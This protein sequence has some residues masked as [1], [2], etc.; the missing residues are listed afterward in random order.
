MSLITRAR[1]RAR[2]IQTKAIDRL[3]SSV[4]RRDEVPNVRLAESIVKKDDEE[5]ILDLIR[6][7]AN[8]D[9]EIQSDCIKVL[10]EVGERKPAMIARFAEEFGALL[11]SKN[12]RVA[13]G[14]MTAL[15]SIA[16][17]RP[18]TL[19]RMMPKIIASANK[20]SVISRDHAVSILTKLASRKEYSDDAVPKLLEQLRRSPNNQLPAYAEKAI[21]IVDDKNRDRFLKVLRSRLSGIQ[22]ESK[23]RRLEKVIARLIRGSP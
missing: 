16:M 1:E 3:A 13:W 11:E 5:A 2:E 19:H 15:D 22:G 23:R 6:N 20:G 8:K 17:E 7:L 9:K 14:A 18:E 10:Y 4:N 21:T 12:N